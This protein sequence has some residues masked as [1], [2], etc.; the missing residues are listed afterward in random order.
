MD[1]EFY[2]I[3]VQKTYTKLKAVL[4]PDRNLDRLL[5]KGGEISLGHAFPTAKRHMNGLYISEPYVPVYPGSPFAFMPLAPQA[6]A[7]G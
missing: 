2:K 7:W 5:K 1:G 4:L 6:K 3:N